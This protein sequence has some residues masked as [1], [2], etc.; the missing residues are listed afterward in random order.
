MRL[1]TAAAACTAF[2]LCPPLA[3]LAAP[4]GGNT[5]AVAVRAEH[6]PR[7]DGKDDDAVWRAAPAF[8]DFHE[9][10]PR[11][12]GP[13]RFRTEFKLAYDDRNFYVFIRAFDPHP[14]SL[15]HALS[16]HDVRGPSD[17]LK[18]LIDPYHDRRS[19]YE[20]AVNPDGVKREYSISADRDE[21]VSWN[22][23]WD[24]ATSIDWLGWTAEFRIPL[25]QLRF[26]RSP[27][28]VFGFG[29]WRDIERFKE[30]VSWPYYRGSRNGLTSQLGD[31]TGISGLPAKHNLEVVPYAVAKNLSR[32][33]PAGF[34]RVQQQTVGGDLK[35]GVTT[36]LTLD[37]TV[38]PD[39]GQVEADPAVLNLSAFE[40]F[41]PEK[42]PFFVEG[43]ALYRFNVNCSIVNCSGEGLFYS[44]RIGRSPSL[45]NR[46]GDASSPTATPIAAAG[47]LTG[48][49]SHGL[50]IGMLDALTPGVAG[51]GGRT[52]EPR[53]NYA[54]VRAQQD[55][56]NGQSGFSLIASAVNRSLDQWT[57][58]ALRR[59]AY[60]AGG[61]F[62]HKFGG[63]NYEMTGSLTAS[64]LAGSEATIAATQRSSVHGFQRPD[65]GLP[66]DSTR[67]TLTGNAEEFAIGKYGGGVT[68]FQTGYQRQSA[69]YDAND[70]GFL[71]RA[72]QQSWTTWGALQ[73][74][75]PTRHYKFAEFNVNQLSQWT[76]AGLR[77]ENGYNTNWHINL[78]NNWWVHAGGTLSR[79]GEVYCDRCARGGPAVRVS[80]SLSPSFGVSGDDR[81]SVVP[82][83]FV[84]FG[85]S[86]EGRSWSVSASPS[87][88]F[89]LSTRLSTS[90]GLNWTRGTDD[91]Q[92]YGNVTDSM[93]V[94]H[95]TFA[96]L[97]QRTLS[98][99][100]RATYTVTPDLTLEFYGQPF[101][102]TGSYSDVRQLSATPRAA[103]Y[104]ARYAPFTPP[105]GSPGGF[106][107]SQ[108]RSNTV[109][110]WEY[111]PGSTLFVVWQ[112]GRQAF[113]PRADARSWRTEYGDL[114]SLY[115]DNTFLVKLA[116]WFSR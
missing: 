5:T 115:P 48:R 116:Y 87:V 111:Q 90:L 103:S 112:H 9:F 13:P 16:R 61:D 107:F 25:S 63:G 94:T 8:S 92:W 3:S 37:A 38:N 82:Q 65:G 97:D 79:E 10:L 27:T 1:S 50:S 64:R 113:D 105:A 47:K 89:K 100:A 60:V 6:P 29:I 68:R 42:R 62:R 26:A 19:G 2:L 17:Q 81:Q 110:R 11:E 41:F 86:D 77:L 108:L 78:N 28:Q 12:D 33:S 14:D 36:N 32:P 51:T 18:I 34:G 70:L 80:P 43:A 93:K 66:Y 44:R 96:R 88:A 21:D 67:T 46:Y 45:R 55:L 76:A 75:N 114:F 59:S 106:V 23:V 30:R 49:L 56:R 53:T 39:F 35:F 109:I 74:R 24:V 83:L 20:F 15:M 54:L 72:D 84:N 101:V 71:L 73:F 31:V 102:T 91:L 104:A 95:Y 57:D 98:L 22:G 7:I 85:R 52:I 99:T 4:Q 40:S 69:G 58:D